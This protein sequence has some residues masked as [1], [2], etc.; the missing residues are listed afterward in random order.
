MKAARQAPG[1]SARDGVAIRCDAAKRARPASPCETGRLQAGILPRP[2]TLVVRF[3]PA[4]TSPRHRNR[5]V[6][7]HGPTV[8][9]F[10]SRKFK[11]EIPFT[12]GED[13][14]F[15]PNVPLFAGKRVLTPDGKDGDAN[16]AVIKELIGRGALLSKGTLR[17]QYPHSWRSKAPV[18]FRATPQWFAAIDKPF[19][20][21]NEA[22]LRE[23]AVGAIAAT[24]WYPRAGE[25]RIVAMVRDRPDWV[26]RASAPG[27]AHRRFVH[28]KSGELLRDDAVNARIADASR[29]KARTPGSTRRRRD[30]S[31]SAC[32]RIRAGHRHL[33]VGS[34]PFHP[35]FVVENPITDGWPKKDR[36]DLYLE[37]SDQ[38]R[39]WFQSSLLESCGTRGRAPYEAVLTHGFVLD[40]QGRKMSKS[41]GN[42]IAPQKVTQQ[43]GAEILRLWVASSDFTEDLRIGPEIIKA[44][45]ESYRRLRNT[46]RFMLANLA[47]FDDGERLAHAEMPELE[48]FVLARLAA[49]DRD[50]RAHYESYDFTPF[51]APVQFRYQRSLGVLFR[52][53]QRRALLRS[54]IEHAPPCRA[55]DHRRAVQPPRAWLAP[56]LVFTMEEAG[57]RAPARTT[58][59]ISI[60]SR[61][62]RGVEER[63]ARQDLGARARSAPCG[64]RALELR[65]AAKE[66]GSSLEAKPTLYVEDPMD[67]ALFDHV[68]LPKSSSPRARTW[69]SAGAAGCVSPSRC[70]WRGGGLRSC[71][72]QEMRPLLDGAPGSR[73]QSPPSRSLPPL[74]RGGRRMT[75]ARQGAVVAVAAL[76]ADQ[77]F[78]NVLLY[79]FD[80]RAR[81]VFAR[82]EV[83]PFLDLVMVWNRGV[84]YGLFQAGGLTGTIVLTVFSLVAVAALSWWL[85]SADRRLLA[86]GLGLVI[87]G[88][89]G[90][91]IDR[92]LWGGADFFHFHAF[93][94]DWYVSTWPTPPSRLASWRF[95]RTRSCDPKQR[96]RTGSRQPGNKTWRDSPWMRRNSSR[97]RRSG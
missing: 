54:Q 64:H 13:G 8:K 52:H 38:H 1:S 60:A 51:S 89:L 2:A 85:R 18:I 58:P 41:L 72:R 29:S 14:S 44:S 95:L 78:K 37:G 42:V 33:D 94:R 91:V 69:K 47:G 45:V 84:S 46:I 43:N 17:H 65:R 96:T 70:R 30:S 6:H 93:G 26:L 21:S 50:V 10:G 77:T 34:T 4:T 55:Y 57:P 90:N 88:A 83:T 19:A 12:V 92:I 79:G 59:C 11:I 80:F 7:T 87:G 40:E 5:G 61:D 81:D 22:T 53:S 49:L 15:L 28:R 39:G 62:A 3:S 56:L 74:Q 97:L 71:R 48:R 31:P 16:G 63:R 20:G 23:L 68:D 25:N 35:A 66:I 36:A 82:I 76:A 24:R 67:A 32:R 86:W 9:T 75:Y 73:S 27:R